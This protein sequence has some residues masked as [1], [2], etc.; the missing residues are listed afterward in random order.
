MYP[1]FLPNPE[2]AVGLNADN[3]FVETAP[4]VSAIPA[5]VGDATIAEEQ[6]AQPVTTGVVVPLG[7]RHNRHFIEANTKPVDIAHLKKIASFPYSAR[8]TR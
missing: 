4:A 8:T 5:S 6:S 2:F 7:V 1:A 3:P